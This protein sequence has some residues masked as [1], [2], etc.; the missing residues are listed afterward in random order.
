MKLI[1]LSMLASLALLSPS[2][3]LAAAP[4]K[5]QPVAAVEGTWTLTYADVVHADGTRG[6]DYGDTPKGLLQIDHEGRYSLLIFDSA[7]PKFAAGDKKKGTPEEFRAALMGTSSH[8]GT[9]SA[10]AAT[11]AL[12]FHIEGSSYPNWEGTTQV[13]N[14]ELKGDMLS[15]KVP[16]RDNGDVPVSAW[17]RLK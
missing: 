11:G 10:D 13:R 8:F 9:V 1:H 7:R 15:Y 12:T 3:V 17:K 5:M 2:A 16:P 4:V 14:Y 6:H